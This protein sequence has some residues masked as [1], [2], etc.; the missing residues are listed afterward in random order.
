MKAA[1]SGIA[2]LVLLAA[3]AAVVLAQLQTADRAKAADPVRERAEDLARSASKR[4]GEV[5]KDGRPAEAEGKQPPA[6]SAGDD[7]WSAARKW[8]ERSSHDYKSIVRR[9]SKGGGAV[10]AQTT[11]PPGAPTAKVAEPQ[12]RPVAGKT[13]PQEGAGTSDW[14]SRSSE[15]FQEIMRKLAEGAAPPHEEPAAR[16]TG[17]EAK[18]PQPPAKP[19]TKPKTEPEKPAEVVQSLRRRSLPSR[20]QLRSRPSRPGP[21]SH[22]RSAGWRKRAERRHPSVR[23]RSRRPRRR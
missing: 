7:P 21:S 1:R 4:F 15:R 22:R 14:L 12:P 16:R 3:G 23:P 20:R 5:L 18:S 17:S 8:L 2:A 10:T 11:S 6:P 13:E 9:L 19:Q